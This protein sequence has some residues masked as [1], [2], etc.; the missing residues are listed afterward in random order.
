[1]ASRRT[2]KKTVKFLTGELFADCVA[3]SMCQQCDKD[4]LHE[5]MADIIKLHTDFVSR[6][7]HTERGAERA[8]YRKFHSEFR[9]QLGE[10]GER[11]MKA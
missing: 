11:I 9:Q 5:L 7:S 8:F 6:I 10:L 2:L 1:M 4:K 3:L